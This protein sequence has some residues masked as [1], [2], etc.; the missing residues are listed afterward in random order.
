M[1][2]E[3]TSSEIFTTE[4]FN[5]PLGN[6]HSASNYNLSEHFNAKFSQHGEDGLLEYLYSIIPI[7]KNLLKKLKKEE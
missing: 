7:K 4:N 1:K 5:N 2:K 3:Y 6:N